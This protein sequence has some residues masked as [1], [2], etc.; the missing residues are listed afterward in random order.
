MAL[1]IFN[2]AS[3]EKEEF[4]PLGEQVGMYVC[5]MTPKFHPHIGHAW[6]FVSLDVVC[7][8]L[9]FSGY[10]LRH[11]QNFTDV[12]DKIIARGQAEGIGAFEAAQKYTRS[13]FEDMDALF[14][15]R[16]DVMPRVTDT[17]DEIIRVIEGLIAKDCAYPIEGNVWFSVDSFPAYGK[18]SHRSD[19]DL[20]A[21]A[22]IEVEPNK[23]N[24]RDF[25]LWKRAKKGEPAWDSPWGPGRPGWHIECTSMVFKE[26]GQQIDIHAGGRDLIFPHHEN[27]IA[28]SE[29]YSGK[30]PF[31][32]YWVHVGLLGIGGDKMSHSLN[33]FITIKDLLGRYG[34]ELLRFYLVSQHYRTP[35][36]YS[37]ENIEA[38]GRALERV[39]AAGAALHE[40][41]AGAVAEETDGSRER[42][43]R[44]VQQ[45]R[46]AREAFVA[47]LDDDFN[48][49]RALAALFD[50]VHEIN[51]FKDGL[52]PGAVPQ[53]GLAAVHKT[54][55]MFREML[56]VLGVGL[57]RRSEAAAERLPPA[58]RIQ[59]LIEQRNAH[60][61][62][63]QFADADRIRG[64][65]ADLGVVL[66]DRPE[67]T[68][69]RPKA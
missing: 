13:Y 63:R 53:T 36:A 45:A 41:M 6:L 26:L 38:A 11:V 56:D 59:E 51:R 21:G 58:E 4:V 49:P 50:L 2:T 52:V 47:G 43:D 31:G 25:A 3:G 15:Q 44:L 14:V 68:V 32:R 18:L 34:P 54:H 39:E 20:L 17:M 24:P 69:W 1:R 40:I 33:N 42:A 48:T 67:G 9:K 55:S 60:R 22:R 7:R 64:E 62:Q 35:I 19:D 29:S 57:R 5:G 28:Q 16:P 66:E 8:Y 37:P 46:R 10:N 65:L 61:R 23:R 27:E 12:D 30:V